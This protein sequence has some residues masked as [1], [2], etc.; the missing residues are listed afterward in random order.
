MPTNEETEKALNDLLQAWIEPPNRNAENGVNL[1]ALL[2]AA[3]GMRPDQLPAVVQTL[4]V[5][6]L[7]DTRGALLWMHDTAIVLRTPAGEAIVREALKGLDRLRAQMTPPA[8]EVR[9]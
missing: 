7:I 1:F 6:G 5:P 9:H 4:E 2:C 8:N 3:W